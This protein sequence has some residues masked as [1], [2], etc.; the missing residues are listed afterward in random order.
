MAEEN[1]SQELRLQNIIKTKNYFI[2]NIDQ[3]ELMTKN[4]KKV[5]TI[6]NYIEHFL[7]LASAVTGCI[8]ISTFFLCLVFLYELWVLRKD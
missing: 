2:K 5:C 7:I 8:L 3:N 1:T 4:H 6:L